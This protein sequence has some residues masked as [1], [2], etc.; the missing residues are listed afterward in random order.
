MMSPSTPLMPSKVFLF[1]RTVDRDYHWMRSEPN[2]THVEL[3]A[4]LLADQDA[5]PDSPST[6]LLF[7]SEKEI[8]IMVARL[9]TDRKDHSM[10]PI[11][12]TLC[13]AF[14]TKDQSKVYSYAAWLLDNIHSEE[15]RKTLLL[16]S[17]KVFNKGEG[18]LPELPP[19]PADS[20]RQIDPANSNHAYRSNADNCLAVRQYLLNKS[21]TINGEH[22]SNTETRE[23]VLSTGLVHLDTLSNVINDNNVN[24]VVA[25]SRSSSVSE[26]GT[27]LKKKKLIFPLPMIK[28]KKLLIAL[29]MA[30]ALILL[31]LFLYY[32]KS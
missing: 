29:A 8:S 20:S 14:D 26:I 6:F 24:C 12:N 21:S 32:N 10:T 27:S 4:R 19:P 17:E 28:S 22:E 16:E 3:N 2:R 31:L 7:R 25:L 11:Y 5:N 15:I 30:F 18:F 9:K 23:L 13:L 1:T